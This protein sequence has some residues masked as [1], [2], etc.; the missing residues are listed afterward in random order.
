MRSFSAD[1]SNIQQAF[2]PIIILKDPF[3]E[4]PLHFNPI[5]RE[6]RRRHYDN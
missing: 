1:K 5:T 3:N 4:E 6:Q 2:L